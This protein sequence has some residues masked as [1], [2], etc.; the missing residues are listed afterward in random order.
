MAEKDHKGKIYVYI[1]FNLSAENTLTASDYGCNHHGCNH[2]EDSDLKYHAGELCTQS[3]GEY[4][5]RQ[6]RKYWL[7][8]AKK[9]QFIAF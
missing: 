8:P 7:C 1:Y 3:F 9:R 2:G 4:S 5:V 6:T